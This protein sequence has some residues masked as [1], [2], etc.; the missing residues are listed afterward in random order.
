MKLTNMQFIDCLRRVVRAK[1]LAIQETKHV[2]QRGVDKLIRAQEYEMR[3]M[4]VVG[5]R[6]ATDVF[7]TRAEEAAN[8]FNDEAR[9]LQKQ[10]KVTHD[11][12]K[13]YE[14][15][16]QEKNA[17]L[18]L[19]E[20]M[21]VKLHTHIAVS[22]R[23]RADRA[24]VQRTL[25]ARLSQP[26]GEKYDLREDP[27]GEWTK[28]RLGQRAFDF[29]GHHLRLQENEIERAQENALVTELKNEIEHYK[30]K[31]SAT[32]ELYTQARELCE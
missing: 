16:L 30:Q 28:T 8:T 10:Y 24:L 32:S 4:E 17:K 25:S 3:N 7:N 22:M 15:A 21:L 18:A 12:I 27:N 19:Q 14:C 9:R 5:V 13:Y 1:V 29:Y 6:T 11:L 2:F 26:L 31:E 20:C 23:Q